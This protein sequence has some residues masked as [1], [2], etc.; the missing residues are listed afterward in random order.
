MSGRY[1]LNL[2][3]LDKESVLLQSINKDCSTSNLS[4]VKIISKDGDQVFLHRIVLTFAFPQFSA[5]FPEGDSVTILIND[6]PGEDVV[7][8]R[9]CLYQN[10]DPEPLAE[11]LEIFGGDCVRVKSELTE[12]EPGDLDVDLV[13]DDSKEILKKEREKELNDE[14]NDE[15]PMSLQELLEPNEPRFDNDLIIGEA[16]ANFNIYKSTLFS[17]NYYRK[18]NNEEAECLMCEL[19]HIK[20][21]LKITDGNTKGNSDNQVVTFHNNNSLF[22]RFKRSSYS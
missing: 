13:E 22:S 21:V 17:H 14:E 10:G 1:N 15:D 20:T 16:K 19:S 5:M 6:I 3:F 12:L 7:K 9:T 8:A 2:K 18:K 11:I 4:D